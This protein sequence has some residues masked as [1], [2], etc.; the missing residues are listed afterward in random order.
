MPKG[1]VYILECSD[2]SYYTGSTTDIEQRIQQHQNG[3]G[4]NHTKKRLPVKLVYLEEFQRID[5]AFYREK[6]IQGW[7]RLKKEALIEK[8]YTQLPELSLAYRDKVSSRA[9]DT[10]KPRASDTKKPRASD[11]N[12]PKSVSEALEDTQ[13][14]TY[15]SHG[16]LLI[17]AEYAVL[18]GALALALPTKFGQSLTVKSINEPKLLWRSF[19]NE[20]IVWFEETF[21]FENETLNCTQNNNAISKRLLDILSTAKKLNPSFLNTQ[22]GY[23]VMSTLEF[24]QDWGLGSSSTLINNIANWAD[25]DAYTLLEETFGGS[26]YDIACA[27]HNTAITY[28]LHATTNKEITNSR[29][30]TTVDFNPSFKEHLYFIHLNKKQNS[31]EGIAIYRKQVVSNE[32]LSEISAITKD[33]IACN[34]LESFASLLNKHEDIISEIIKLEP[35]KKRLFNDFRGSIK[36]L[37]A[38]G[39][40]FILAASKENPK[41]YFKD[42]GFET[43]IPYND[44]ILHKKSTT[45]K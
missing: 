7:N 24:P 17:S 28:Q 27:K 40:D 11:T 8:H 9:S 22:Q 32:T 14:K 45:K 3:Q 39:G 35:V 4:A 30:I 1:F 20:G 2:G 37:G 38:W 34:S 10:K 19:N 6:Q 29:T 21:T 44:M 36:S 25:V 15:Y 33:M 5:D 23:K 42:K 16:K 12:V 43:I 31:R 13:T 41:S 18:D 26:G